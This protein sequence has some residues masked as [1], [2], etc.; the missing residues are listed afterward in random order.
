VKIGSS[1]GLQAVV[2]FLVG[3]SFTTIYI[4]QPVLPILQ[5]EFGVDEAI[6]SLTI[7][8]VIFG[9]ALSNLPLGVLADLY[10]IRPII[11][12][13]SFVVIICCLFCA[14]TTHI[15]LLIVARFIQG[16]SIP[17]LTTCLAAYL[18]RNLP[19]ESLNVV[20]GSYVSATVAGGL[21]GRLLGGWIHALFHWRLAFV[22]ATVLLLAA[23][24]AASRGL[25]KKEQDTKTES[26]EMGMIELITQR[27]LLSIYFLAFGAFFVF[28]SIFNYLPFYL[29]EPSFQV[30]TKV[31]TLLYL[32]YI[33]GIIIGPL[34]GKL[35]NQIGNGATIVLGVAVFTISIGITLIKSISA[36]IVSLIGICASFFAIH[37]AAAGSLNRKLTAS[38][39]R[40]NSLYVL[41]YYLGGF[42]GITISGYAYIFAGWR[43]VAAIGSA[44]LLIL[45]AIGIREMIIEKK[46]ER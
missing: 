6:A 16:L 9:I 20:M 30:P 29:S 12:T 42:I 26:Q 24:I 46:L 34:A 19:K 39:G 41:F 17:S 35:S 8:A 32:S 15:H 38:R 14:V 2:F 3:A 45:L 22:C 28:S 31:I 27:D 33:I 11:L 36:I 18:S 1:I 44:I 21:S 37:A 43:G 13:G 4:T 5:M 23:T 40:A 10:S 25:P 7:S